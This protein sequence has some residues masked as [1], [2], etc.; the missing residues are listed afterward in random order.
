M[1]ASSRS[2]NRAHNQNQSAHPGWSPRAP[3]SATRSEPRAEQI[4]SRDAGN[5]RYGRL[6]RLAT[7]GKG[8]KKNPEP[9]E[10]RQPNEGRCCHIGR[11]G[12]GFTG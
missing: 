1:R 9:I 5:G 8:E 11:R 4:G 6:D 3:A 12:G 7:N 10:G 2:R